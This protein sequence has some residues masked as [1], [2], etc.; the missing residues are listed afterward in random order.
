MNKKKKPD[1]SAKS[2]MRSGYTSETNSIS[3][4]SFFILPPLNICVNNSIQKPIIVR[5]LSDQRA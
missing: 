1:N 3:A 5:L 4:P 2:Q